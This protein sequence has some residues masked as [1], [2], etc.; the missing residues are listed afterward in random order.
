MKRSKR[1]DDGPVQHDRVRRSPDLV[2]VLGA[3]PLGHH[4]IDLH[5]A[6]L[7]GPADGVLQVYSIFGP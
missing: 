2:H 1:A 3:E 4:E 5:R 6:E 7:P